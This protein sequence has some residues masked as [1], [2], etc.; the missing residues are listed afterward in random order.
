MIVFRC[1]I[2]C[3]SAPHEGS[4]A[5]NWY[6]IRTTFSNHSTASPHLMLH[7]NIIWSNVLIW[8]NRSCVRSQHVLS[9]FLVHIHF[10][11]NP[12]NYLFNCKKRG[13]GEA[14]TDKLKQNNIVKC[15]TFFVIDILLIIL[16]DMKCPWKRKFDNLATHRCVVRDGWWSS[17]LFLVN[18]G[19]FPTC[20]QHGETCLVM[21][22]PANWSIKINLVESRLSFVKVCF[23]DCQ[24]QAS[25]SSIM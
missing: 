12:S 2:I 5:T 20:V 3:E 22:Y 1:V 11:Q 17:S 7:W 8:S 24:D 14:W 25:V 4:Q 19:M 16:S 10:Q 15:E 13:G 21:F 18:L 9:A 23:Q 6:S